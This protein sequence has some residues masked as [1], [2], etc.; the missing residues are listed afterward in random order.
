M[1]LAKILALVTIL[2]TMFGAGLQID[3]ARLLKTLRNYGLLGR[4]MLAN[5]VLV[6]LVAVMLV[7]YLHVEEAA[8][9]GIVLMAMAPGVP[10]LVN[11]AGRS[12][13]GSLSFA[14]TISFVFSALSV[15]TIPITIA[16]VLP[17]VEAR[18]PASHFLTT[19]LAGQLLPLVA[20]AALAPRLSDAA[21]EKL[22]KG[23]NLLFVA[24]ALVLVVM[25]F[26]R[27]VSSVSSVYGYGRLAIIAGIGIFSIAIGWFFGGPEETYR[28]TLSI[29]TLM[30]NI[31]LC[32][33]IGTED[34]FAGTLL[35][36]TVIA[37]LAVTFVLSLP[38][39]IYFMRTKNARAAAH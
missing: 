17:N 10:F 21:A 8:A 4:A 35:L 23:L 24:A 1:Q 27:L 32:M 11:S 25:L 7:R 5:F 3:R 16:L 22:V 30:R 20:G 2:A 9:T 31:G 37:Y 33:L 19:L 14:I 34:A 13:G 12:G 28:R 36:P 39:R 18:V 15:V 38:V 6:P 26:P 29:A